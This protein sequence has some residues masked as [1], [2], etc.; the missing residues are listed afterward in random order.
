MSQLYYG[1]QLWSYQGTHGPEDVIEPYDLGN[2]TGTTQGH[3]NIV[4]ILLSYGYVL[5]RGEFSLIS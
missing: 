3:S 4:T 2:H 1:V 5:M